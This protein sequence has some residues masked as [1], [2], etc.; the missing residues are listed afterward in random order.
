M[1][2]S[3]LDTQGY[4]LAIGSRRLPPWWRFRLYHHLHKRLFGNPYWCDPVRE[5]A[6]WELIQPHGYE[7]ELF[8]SDWM[9]RYALHTGH[10]YCGEVIATVTTLLRAGDSFLDIGANLGFVTLTASRIVGQQGRVFAIEP[11]PTL[12]TRL[13]RMLSHNQI[14]NVEVLPYAA[15]D[16]TGSIGLSQ[17]A[18]HGN[19]QLI[20]DL[21][22]APVVVPMHR[23]DDLLRGRL[24]ATGR[25]MVKIDVEG[26]EPMVLRGMPELISRPETMFL[27]EVSD[28]R[29]RQGGSSADAL[30]GTMRTNGYSAFLPSFAP[31]SY[32]LRLSPLDRLPRRNKTYDVL[33]RRPGQ[34]A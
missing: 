29:L 31:W 33:F 8:R 16:S 27:V 3:A 2:Q 30:F 13:T 22:A 21:A 1:P 18:H 26:A 23:V 17:D 9:E 19:N 24:P 28:H 6:E 11:N 10:F 25:L 5:P 20:A 34:N 4:F 12:V 15:G 14:S 7:M 32:R